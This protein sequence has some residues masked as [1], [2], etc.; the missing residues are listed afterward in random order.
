MRPA[1]VR[2][3]VVRLHGNQ[4]RDAA[5]CCRVPGD[6]DADGDAAERRLDAAGQ[7]DA[8]ARLEPRH[9]PRTRLCATD[10]TRPA[11]QQRKRT[12][13]RKVPGSRDFKLKTL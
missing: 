3:L 4:L 8:E 9:L 1:P 2:A 5:G 6:A 11:R 7:E 13:S 10:R 12:V